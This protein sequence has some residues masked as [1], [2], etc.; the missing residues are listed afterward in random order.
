MG[1]AALPLIFSELTR[2]PNHWFWA[3][4]SI[5]GVNPIEAEDQGDLKAMASA[6]LRWAQENSWID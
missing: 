2:E 6:W 4:T 3:L 5:T 1:E